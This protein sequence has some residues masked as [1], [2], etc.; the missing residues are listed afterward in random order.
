M[1]RAPAR[2]LS[3]LAAR[4]DAVL[5]RIVDRVAQD[6]RVVAA[7][8]T[9]S[10]GR[11]ED[12]A[13]SDLDLHLAIEDASLEEW[14]REREALYD[15][16]APP[17]FVQPEKP[18]NAQAG[19]HFQLVSVPGPVE[20]DWNVGP[21]SLATRPS[22]SRMLVARREIP[23]APNPPLDAEARR[24][25]LQR[26]TDFFWAMTPIAVKY[27]GRGATTD[28]VD[29][30]DLLVRAVCGVW[31]VLH[32]S[33]NVTSPNPRF[34]RDLV[35]ILPALGPAIDPSQCLAGIVQAMSAMEDLRPDLEL[36]GVEWPAALVAQ[37]E[38]LVAIARQAIDA[39]GDL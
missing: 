35:A 34:E 31:W 24:Q 9:G 6:D 39:R 10:F 3:G 7:W 25:R 21:V 18:S 33:E 22:T 8:L 17:L 4:R 1:E 28:A 15:E 38:A 2:T 16:I 19:G 5:L 27:A 32:G 11:G 12:D 36:A 14:W 30:I 26:E 13:W 23:I 37:T 29:Q 20:V